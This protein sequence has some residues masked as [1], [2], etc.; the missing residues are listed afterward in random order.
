MGVQD[1]ARRDVRSP[2]A[3]L[4]TLRGKGLQHDARTPRQERQSYGYTKRRFAGHLRIFQG[5]I[6]AGLQPRVSSGAWTRIE[7][8]QS[9]R[10]S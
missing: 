5:R 10:F 6:S 3:Y 9:S 7:A 1:Y 4:N 2:L 8:V